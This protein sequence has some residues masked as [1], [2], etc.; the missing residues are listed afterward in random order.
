VSIAHPNNFLGKAVA[1]FKV[2]IQVL[3]FVGSSSTEQQSLADL[4]WGAL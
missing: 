3:R 4:D 2:E 1:L